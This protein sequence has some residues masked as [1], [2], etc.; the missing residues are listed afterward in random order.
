MGE[1]PLQ[2]PKL[3]EESYFRGL[4][5]P[6]RRPE[7]SMLSV[8]QSACMQRVSTHKVDDLLKALGLNGIDRSKSSRICRGP[9]DVVEAFR[10]RPLKGRQP[11]LWLNSL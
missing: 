5:E 3:R 10:D 11:Y 4:V 7:Q 6:R 8:I 1:I 2:I 9:D